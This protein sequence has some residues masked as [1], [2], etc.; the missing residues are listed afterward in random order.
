MIILMGLPGSGK[1]TMALN[2]YKNYVRINQDELGT[3]NDCIEAAKLA[4][5][6]DQDLIVD[7]C[8]MTRQQRAFW[9]TL[10]LMYNADNIIGLYVHTDPEECIARIV[11]RKNHPTIKEELTVEKKREIVYSFH[12]TAQVPHLDEGFSSIVFIRG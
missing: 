2:K 5:E 8:N 3:R 4:M 11:E 1:S 7:R 9:I 10:A 12:H 6:N